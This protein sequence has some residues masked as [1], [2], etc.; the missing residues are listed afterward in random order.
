MSYVVRLA[1][2]MDAPNTDQTWLINGNGT[3][4][5]AVGQ[6]YNTIA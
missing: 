3:G 6:E 1:Y 2:L 4:M 5:S